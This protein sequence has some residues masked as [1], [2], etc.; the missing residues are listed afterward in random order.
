M[1]EV[2]RIW[3]IKRAFTLGEGATAGASSANSA[4]RP[5]ASAS[6]RAQSEHEAI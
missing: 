3:V 2:A 5:R 4:M 6:L 1:G